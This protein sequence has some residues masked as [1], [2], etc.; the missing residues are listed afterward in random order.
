[1]SQTVSLYQPSAE[2]LF[3]L[4]NLN[5]NPL[6]VCIDLD[7]TLIRT[8]SL[9][10][11]FPRVLFGVPQFLCAY[12][13]TWAEF[14]TWMALN[15]PIDVT[16][17]P[18]R[19][20]LLELCRLC[21]ARNVPVILATGA[22]LETARS[23]SK[24]LNCFHDIVAST[25][26]IHCVGKHKAEAL[27]KRYGKNNFHYFG[28]SMQDLFVWQEANTTIV[29]DPSPSFKRVVTQRSATLGNKSI[30]LYDKTNMK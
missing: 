27:V 12:S 30:F 26:E 1:M 18:Y 25:K 14:K 22:A 23:V 16:S 9:Y 13:W 28:D 29:L 3:D 4:L 8:S 20:V 21:V 7:F 10:F 19:I 17:L 15:Y 24:H 11:F 6:P 5:D 2:K